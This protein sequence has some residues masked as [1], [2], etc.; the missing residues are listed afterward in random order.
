MT[1]KEIRSRFAASI[2]G[3]IGD[4]G[5]LADLEKQKATKRLLVL[6]LCMTAKAFL[7]IWS[8]E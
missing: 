1:R 8:S 4:I 7:A 6:A 2:I 3:L 5:V